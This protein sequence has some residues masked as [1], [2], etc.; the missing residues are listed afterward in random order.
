M[1]R[2]FIIGISD[3]RTINGL[4]CWQTRSDFVPQKNVRKELGSG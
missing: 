2:E 1:L 4:E 3:F